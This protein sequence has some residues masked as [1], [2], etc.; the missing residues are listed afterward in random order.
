MAKRVP[1]IAAGPIT[2]SNSWTATK[3]PPHS[4]AQI[5]S[6]TKARL[7]MPGNLSQS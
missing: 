5:V 3:T 7:C 6:A 1:T 4:A 2:G